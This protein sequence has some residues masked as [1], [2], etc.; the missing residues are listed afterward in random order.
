MSA[1][2]G[3]EAADPADAVGDHRD[4][5]GDRAAVPGGIPTARGVHRQV[6][7]VLGQVLQLSADETHHGGHHDRP[8]P[9][10]VPTQA[11]ELPGQQAAGLEARQHVTS[12]V[13]TTKGR[14]AGT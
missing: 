14:R 13:C 8:R 10:G 1:V 12:F 4:D 2:P 3:Q 5:P 9:V 7:G 6:L 11:A